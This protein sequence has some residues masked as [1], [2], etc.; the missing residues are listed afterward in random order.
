MPRRVWMYWHQGWSAAPTVVRA[1]ADSWRSRNPDWEIEL[2]DGAG[3]VAAELLPPAAKEIAPALPALSDLLRLALLARHGGVWA[4]ATLWCARPLDDW[5]G[6]ATRPSGFFGYD[7]PSADRPVDSWLL[8]ASPG[9]YVARRWHGEAL[10]LVEETRRR[11]ARRRA[12]ANRVWSK[13][14][15]ARERVGARC[16]ILRFRHGAG[17]VW[18]RPYDSLA[19]PT[20]PHPKLGVYFWM[21][22]LF[23]KLLE[24]DEEFRRR[25]AATPKIRAAGPLRL[26]DAG[27]ASPA[28]RAVLAA[29]RGPA[30]HVFKT[31]YKGDLPRDLSGTVLGALFDTA[32]P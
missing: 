5:I 25:W 30:A 11:A 23:R 10:R 22:Y 6:P 14:R 3:D 31:T 15:Y 19:M 17:R 27:M 2:L 28:S 4:D 32:R 21:Q 13:L 7:R 9:N 18:G 20:V 16:T 8:A 12:S 26:L 29:L 24:E 1:C